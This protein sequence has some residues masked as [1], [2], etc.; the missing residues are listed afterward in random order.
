MQTV[1]PMSR[2]IKSGAA[3][4]LVVTGSVSLKA[5]TKTSNPYVFHPISWR[6][7]SPLF[8]QK[9]ALTN[10]RNV[11][12]LGRRDFVCPHDTCRRAFGYKHLL[13]RHLGKLHKPDG[14]SASQAQEQTEDADMS[15][16]DVESGAEQVREINI[17]DIT[18]KSYAMRAQQQLSSPRTLRCPHPDLHGLVPP[19]DAIRHGEKQCEYVFTRAY[20][21]RRHLRSEHGQDVEKDVVDTWVRLARE[22]KNASAD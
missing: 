12:H 5:A 8:V 21:L 17:D 1:T 15:S 10:H 13:Q 7:H 2:H 3:A 20:D 19:A 18:G 22:A 11:N 4:K 6:V 16:D 9:K 14:P